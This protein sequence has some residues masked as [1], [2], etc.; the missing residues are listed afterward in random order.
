MIH[1]DR[2]DVSEGIDINKISLSKEFVI[3]QYQYFLDEGFKFQSDV[4]NGCLYVL[5]I[6]VNLNDILILSIN[7]INQH[8]IISKISKNEAVTL[9]QN[10][11]LTEK[12]KFYKVKK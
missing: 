4:C 8:C 2:I 5:M 6:S 11:E 7:G 10:T 12:N 1:C 9:L 3:C